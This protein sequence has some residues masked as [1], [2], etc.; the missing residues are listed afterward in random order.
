MKREELHAAVV[1]WGWLLPLIALAIL[2]GGTYYLERQVRGQLESRREAAAAEAEGVASSLA[3]DITAE[4]AGRIGAL[5][6]AKVQFTQVEDSL[7]QR[8]FVAAVDSVISRLPGLVAVSFVYP[9]GQILSSRT[10]A[11]AR[12]DEPLQDSTLAASYARAIATRSPVAT[13]VLALGGDRRFVVFDPVVAS[14]TAPVQAVLAAELEP[15]PILRAALDTEARQARPAFYS[16]FDPA[17]S[18]ITTVAAPEGWPSV[19]RPVRVA[20]TE[21]SLFVAH[22][23]VSDR[24]F[25]ATIYAIRVAGLLLAIGFAVALYFLWRMVSAQQREIRMRRGAESQARELSQQLRSAQD[26]SLRLASTVDPDQMIDEFLGAVGLAIGAD[27]GRLYEFENDGEALAGRRLVRLTAEVDPDAVPSE[28]AF[29]QVRL[30]AALV[31]HLAEAVATGEPYLGSGRE[32]SPGA[33]GETRPAPTGILTVPLAIAGHLVGVAVWESYNQDRTFER[34]S[35]PFAQTVAAHAAAALQAAELLERVRQARQRAHKEAARL[36]TVL[37]QLG[38]GVV[39]FEADGRPE[40]VNA[41]AERLLGPDLVASPVSEWPRAFG[42]PTAGQAALK[43][44]PP[45]AALEG[46]AVHN[47][48]Y[49]LHRAGIDRYLA[50]SAAPI[51]GGEEEVRGAVVVLRDVTAE[52]EYAEM[53]RHTNQELRDQAS[54]LERANDELRAATAAKDQFL[55]MMSHELRTPINAIIGYTDLLEVG[56]HGELGEKQRWMLSRVTDTSRHL[57]G[58]IEDVLDLAKIGAGR[59]N[60]SIQPTHLSP[61]VERATAQ[62]APLAEEKGL[63]LARHGG[64]GTRILADETRMLQILINL[65]SNAVKFTDSGSVTIESREEE[66][67][68]W[69]AVTDTGPGIPPGELETVFEEF[70]QVDSGLS[71]KAGGSGLGLAISQR[72]ARLMG[73]D[74]TVASELGVGTTFTVRVPLAG[75]KAHAGGAPQ[76]SGAGS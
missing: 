39:L 17:G 5:A 19:Q 67:F 32:A 65:C 25:L 45:A 33:A 41:A 58:L 6:A 50:I 30:P 23:P 76:T 54:L 47:H 64:D 13:P 75:Q 69:V 29:R 12:E 73:G 1:R 15:L 62:V 26:A 38:D 56:V 63:H 40:R 16:L 52:H 34:E 71:R 46:H 7:S 35:I 14:D 49:T 4:V 8:T 22:Q 60:L 51:H 44:F 9:N 48:R 59:I 66:G 21:W 61:L 55:A 36:A 42:L 53:L 10:A 28:E 74:I 43:G 31:P 27:V 68:A 70:H 18:R 24:P 37:D 20:D 3:E 57:L 11:L 72:L 2:I